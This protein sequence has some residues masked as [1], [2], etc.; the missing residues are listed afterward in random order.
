MG[1]ITK[2]KVTFVGDQ[3][4][5]KTS[6][7]SRFIQDSFEATS[8][9]PYIIMHSAHSGNWFRNQDHASG[10]VDIKIT[11]VGHRR[12]IKVQ[13]INSIICS[14]CRYLPHYSGPFG[15]I[16]LLKPRQMDG[17]CKGHTRRLRCTYFHSRQQG[18]PSITRGL[19]IVTA[20]IRKKIRSHLP[21]SIC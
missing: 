15:K 7:I 14:G 20:T 11:V 8:N 19:R 12:S 4:V 6:I 21:L 2:F 5:G 1:K 9:V 16:K 10:W 13:I 17:L 3:N 18:R